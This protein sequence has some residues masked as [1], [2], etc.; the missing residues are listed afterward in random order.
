M[1]CTRPFKISKRET[2]PFSKEEINEL[3]MFPE[4]VYELTGRHRQHL[5]EQMGESWVLSVVHEAHR[6]RLRLT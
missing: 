5:I 6:R 2:R 1:T 3:G 4:K